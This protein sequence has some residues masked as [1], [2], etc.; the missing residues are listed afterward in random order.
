[1]EACWR[2]ERVIYSSRLLFGVS[3]KQNT[4]LKYAERRS[5]PSP[6]HIAPTRAGFPHAR[7]EHVPV[8]TFRKTPHEPKMN[9]R[10]HPSTVTA[11]ASRGPAN[12]PGPG[13]SEGR[14]SASVN[15]SGLFFSSCVLKPD[16]RLALGLAL[17]VVFWERPV[18]LLAIKERKR[19]PMSAA[20]ACS[21]WCE[22]LSR[23]EGPRR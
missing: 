15:N 23:L 14:T 7:H 8:E 9:Q 22:S 3:A 4:L 16:G 19:G 12:A 21:H 20:A 11:S 2:V 1:M 13:G 5:G 10:V 6:E 18:R 17:A